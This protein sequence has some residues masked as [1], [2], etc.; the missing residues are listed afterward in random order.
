MMTSSRPITDPTMERLAFIRHLYQL[1]V[2]QSRKA[3][4]GN[5][6]AILMLHDAADLLLQLGSE[7]LNVAKRGPTFFTDYFD[8]LAPKVSGGAL[9]E[10][11]AMNRL[12]SA[13]VNLK[14]HGTRPSATDVESLRASTTG[15]FESNV[16]LI[17]GI[18]FDEISMARLVQ[19]PEAKQ[20]LEKAE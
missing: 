7:H 5:A 20:Y 2:E 15:F 17:F 12:N 19:L 14:H 18:T 16:P 3:E 9:A 13:R 11:A 4:P 8:L 10:R 6:I 1:G